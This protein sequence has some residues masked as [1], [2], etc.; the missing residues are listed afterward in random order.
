MISGSFFYLKY[1][2]QSKTISTWEYMKNRF[3]R[4][5]PYT[6]AAFLLLY[7]FLLFTGRRHT[8]TEYLSH[9]ST[10]IWEVLLIDM[11]GINQGSAMLNFP[12]WTISCLLIV[13]CTIWGLLIC[14]RRAFFNLIA[15]F[16]MMVFYGIWS[17]LDSPSYRTWLGVFNFGFIQVWCA[18]MWGIFAVHVADKLRLLK[19][20]SKLLTMIEILNYLAAGIIMFTTSHLYWRFILTLLVFIAV[21]ISL[22]Q[23]SY[24]A[25][26]FRDSKVTRLLA[27][28]SLA[29]YLNHS[30]ILKAFQKLFCPR[31][32]LQMWPVFIL[33]LLAFSFIFYC[34]MK[35]IVKLISAKY[36][37]IKKHYES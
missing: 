7:I 24:S 17:N 23:R 22:S 4:F 6:T 3:L 36:M 37:I 18:V 14:N 12:T 31:E 9:F 2:K 5:F 20:P 16:S 26:L 35:H 8:F 1:R 34:G 15:P 19:K 13:E 10:Y 21:S 11:I 29:I 27:S 30:L 25:I 32:M 33:V 28:L